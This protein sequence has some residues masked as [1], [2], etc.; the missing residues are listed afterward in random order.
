MC[1]HRLKQTME[2]WLSEPHWTGLIAII[3]FAYCLVIIMIHYYLVKTSKQRKTKIGKKLS[4]WST[5]SM[6]LV[7]L[8]P[9]FILLSYFHLENLLLGVNDC[10]CKLWY[11]LGLISFETGFFV[12]N[13]NY[14]IRLNLVVNPLNPNRFS[15]FIAICMITMVVEI[16]LIDWFQFNA[17]EAQCYQNTTKFGCLSRLNQWS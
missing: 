8:F 5:L 17:I 6:I 1:T 7:T 9:I 3:S 13:I 10:F 4:R 11:T 12:L 2:S 16:I 14:L 15:V